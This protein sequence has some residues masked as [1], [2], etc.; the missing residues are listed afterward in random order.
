[1]N[2]S[3]RDALPKM[4]GRRDKGLLLW[5]MA[6]WLSS[7]GGADAGES[8]TLLKNVSWLGHAAVRIEGTKTVYIDPYGI[9]AGKGDADIVL[10]THDHRDHFSTAD[11]GK[12]RGERTVLIGPSSVVGRLSGRT[13]VIEPGK[14][15]SVE[16]ARVR[17][18]P[19]HNV[20][21]SHHPRDKD[22]VGYVLSVDGVT[23]YHAGDTDR[24]P[25]MRA[26]RAAVAFLPVTGT[27]TMDAAAAAS[28]ASDV[29]ARIAIPIHW[30]SVIGSREDAARFKR[31]CRVR[32]EILG[33][34]D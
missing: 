26:I 15:L 16:G 28:A 2:F 1:M 27:Y 29:K 24:I 21:K 23:Y 32:V 22:H 11:I 3:G 10:I 8:V 30:G 18:V 9:S 34:T 19:A 17:A 31:L 25:E 20:G 13:M 7:A 14:T 6:L 12:V 5:C 33:K 4:A